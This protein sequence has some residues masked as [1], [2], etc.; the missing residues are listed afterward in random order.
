MASACWNWGS[1]I[2][3]RFSGSS[4][5]C[6]PCTLRSRRRYTAYRSFSSSRYVPCERAAGEKKRAGMRVRSGSGRAQ[7]PSMHGATRARL[8]A[9]ACTRPPGSNRFPALPPCH[10]PCAALLRRHRPAASTPATLPQRSKRASWMK[11]N[12]CASMVS[13]NSRTS[14]P[15]IAAMIGSYCCSPFAAMSAGEGSRPSSSWTCADEST[16][17]G[18]REGVAGKARS[19]SP[20]PGGT[21]LP[22]AAAATD[23]ATAAAAATTLTAPAATAATHRHQVLEHQRLVAARAAVAA[24]QRVLQALLRLLL[25]AAKAKGQGAGAGAESCVGGR[26]PLRPAPQQGAAAHSCAAP[27]PPPRALPEPPRT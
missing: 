23:T 13:L 20:G 22:A 12:C 15:R 2:C 7:V 27:P 5:A 10:R 17:S 9:H 19:G 14:P 21:A 25:R 1:G 8:R 3:V 4:S 18:A 16:N 24:L 6:T 26:Q 11:R